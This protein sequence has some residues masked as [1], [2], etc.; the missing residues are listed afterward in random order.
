[1][2]RIDEKRE[3]HEDGPISV[4]VLVKEAAGQADNLYVFYKGP[5]VEVSPPPIPYC[6]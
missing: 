5:G 4:K 6:Q 1:M 3:R 2:Y